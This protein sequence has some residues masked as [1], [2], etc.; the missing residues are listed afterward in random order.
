MTIVQN[1]D[2][3]L[4]T[5]YVPEITVGALIEIISDLHVLAK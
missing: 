5:Y 2:Y 4:S 1:N 3:F